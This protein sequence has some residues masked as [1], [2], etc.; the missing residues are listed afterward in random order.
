LFVLKARR[1]SLGN[2]QFVG[3]LF[4]Q[5]MLTEAIMHDCIVKLLKNNEEESLE[6]LCVLLKTIGKDI[7][8][9]KAKAS[10]LCSVFWLNELLNQFGRATVL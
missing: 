3:E 7:E 8:H 5:K 1:R 2:I 9:E 6:C 4:K 10:F